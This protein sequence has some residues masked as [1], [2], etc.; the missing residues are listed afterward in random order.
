[1]NELVFFASNCLICQYLRHSENDKKKD[2]SD[3]NCGPVVFL[4]RLDGHHV[5]FGK[6]LSG[7]DI[8]F[9]IEKQG[10]ENGIP[11]SKVVISDSGELPL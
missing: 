10:R 11:K 4:F 3:V 7:M 5:V 2:D 6:V 1:M 9:K 8:V